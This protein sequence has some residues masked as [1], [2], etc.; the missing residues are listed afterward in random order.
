MIPDDGA[1]ESRASNVVGHVGAVLLMGVVAYVLS[2][3]PLAFCA[4]TWPR[5]KTAALTSFYLPLIWVADHTP[6]GPPL[7]AYVNWWERLGRT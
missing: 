5:E 7:V 2:V 1:D 6:L 4:R 3:G